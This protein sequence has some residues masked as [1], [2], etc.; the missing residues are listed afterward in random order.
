[1]YQYI[2]VELATDRYTYITYT[3]NCIYC[4]ISPAMNNVKQ[5]T[6]PFDSTI[7]LQVVTP[8]STQSCYCNSLTDKKRN[9]TRAY[10]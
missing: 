9:N 1:M 6:G 8:Q 10:D 3:T 5:I 7:R 4:I 2:Y